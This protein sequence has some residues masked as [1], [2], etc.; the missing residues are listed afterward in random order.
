[1]SEMTL[2]TREETQNFLRIGHNTYYRY[3]KQGL[4]PEVRI[5]GKP[6]VVKEELE[7]RIKRQL[8]NA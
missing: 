7:K 8:N 4:I 5:G 2:L 1:M 6:L 3:K